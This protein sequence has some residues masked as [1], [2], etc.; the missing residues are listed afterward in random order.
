MYGKITLFMFIKIFSCIVNKTY[1]NNS[2]YVPSLQDT[3]L[4][5]AEPFAA[6]V[7][8]PSFPTK[9]AMPPLSPEELSLVDQMPDSYL[10]H[11]L[12]ALNG[13]EWSGDDYL[14]VFMA[15]RLGEIP[16]KLKRFKLKSYIQYN[17]VMQKE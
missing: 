6:G 4:F 1:A 15:Y 13:R 14:V 2:A 8:F 12:T 11:F 7:T 9:A 16:S 3:W 17:Q 5:P 10:A